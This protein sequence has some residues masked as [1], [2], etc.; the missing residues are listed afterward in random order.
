[1]FVV[2]TNHLTLLWDARFLFLLAIVTHLSF[3]FF[4]ISGRPEAAG[5]ESSR[6]DTRGGR[7]TDHV[8]T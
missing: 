8:I 5:R 3:W 4:T 2:Y 7:Q 1:M 6:R